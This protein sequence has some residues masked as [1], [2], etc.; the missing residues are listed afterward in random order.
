MTQLMNTLEKNGHTRSGECFLKK[1]LIECSC[2]GMRS[3]LLNLSKWGEKLDPK[4]LKCMLVILQ[5]ICN[6]IYKLWD[7]DNKKVIIIRMVL[8]LYS[9]ASHKQRCVYFEENHEN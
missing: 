7:L 8:I 5:S 2:L 1:P 6:K 3:S 9:K 4:N